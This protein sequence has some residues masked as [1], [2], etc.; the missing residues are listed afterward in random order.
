VSLPSFFGRKARNS[1]ARARGRRRGVQPGLEALG[2]RRLLSTITVNT[3]AD[4]T[5]PDAT[6]SLRQAIEVS[7]GTLA[8]SSLSTQEQAL[9]NGAVSGT[10]TIDFNI[11]TTDS[12][13]DAATGVWAIAVNSALPA[14]STNAAII[15]GYSQAGSSENTEAQADNA[16]L[17]IAL[18]GA[19][20]Q[21]NGLTIAQPGSHVSG[22]DI[23][24]FSSS[25]ILITAAGDVQV[26][27]CFIGTDPTGA[28]AAPNANGV[29][30]ENSSNLIGGPSAGDRNVIS[31]NNQ[32][33]EGDGILLPPQQQNP[34][35]ITPTEN[36]VENNFIG[37]DA[38]GT[39][40]LANGHAGVADFGTAN[41][42]GGTTAGL[43]NVISGNG[44]G[45]ITS[46]SSI[47][48]EG[49]FIG[50]DATGNVALGNGPA[51]SGISNGASPATQVTTVITN[52]VVSGN[53]QGGIGVSV[54]DQQTSVYT[55]SNNKIGTNAAGTMALGNVGG[56]LN[57]DSIE[58]AT[59]VGNL[60]SGNTGLGLS[61]SGFGTDVEHNVFQGNLIGTDITGLLDL[62]NTDA[63]VSF[64]NAIGNLFGGSSAGQGNVVAFNGGDGI[65][66]EETG[67][68][69]S[70]QNRITENSIFG[71]EGTGIYVF[72]AGANN[73]VVPPTLTFTPLSGGT[74]TLKATLVG[75]A[76]NASYVVE[77]FSNPTVP[78]AGHVAETTFIEAM[79]VVADGSGHGS[80]SVTVPTGVYTATS[81]DSSGNT[82][83]FSLPVG[84]P[85]LPATVTS[86]TS[87]LNSSTVGQQVTFTA[88]VTAGASPTAPTGSVVFT[89]DG[90][91]QPSVPLTVVGG[92]DEAQFSTST[93]IAG[94]HSISAA[95]SGDANFSSS[96]GT[97]PTQT[98]DAPNLTVTTTAVSSSSN[99]SMVGQQV[100]FTAVVAAEV[101]PTTPTGSVVFTID[102]HA[103]PPVPLTVVGGVDEAQFAT[104]TLAAR[105]HSVSATYDGE[106]E[107]ATSTGTLPTQTV[108]AALLVV[109]STV[110]STT[111][112]PSSLGHQVVLTAT[113][114]AADNSSVDG[115]VTFVVGKTPVGT[116]TIGP[117]GIATFDDPSLP[118]GSNVITANYSGDVMH[119]PSTSNS[120]AQVVERSSIV[121]PAVVAPAVVLLQRYGYHMQPTTLVLTFN[122]ALDAASAENVHAY[123]IV[124]GSGRGRAGTL[125][126]RKVGIRK[127][128]YNPS[129][130]TVTLV[131]AHRLDVHDTYRLMVDG[132]TQAGLRGPSGILLDAIAVGN[133]GTNYH[134]LITWRTLAG[135]APGFAARTTQ[136]NVDKVNLQGTNTLAGSS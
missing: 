50:T 81:T 126:G 114:T 5:T 1:Q 122:T 33:G 127:A 15:D 133:P 92:V 112:S 52:N 130:L 21:F 38:A 40:A 124:A 83:V 85:G 84:T 16:R 9:V 44:G 45:G 125:A 98:V 102:G 18:N 49:N 64:S 106:S 79:T 94:P 41:T 3:T 53:L 25:G 123:H 11:P 39:M 103:Q 14:I 66:I 51:S 71:N 56:G 23:E 13:Y 4:D 128:I 35:D 110:L 77:I 95:Y 72:P 104:S 121:A 12:G 47:T 48:I 119:A 70:G 30:I 26:A 117:N 57:L 89:I 88:V 6:L 58:N 115:T 93:L 27:G 28:M 54:G 78:A 19:G 61:L 91:A 87:S 120:V 42:Y 60:I 62:G 99:P 31:G 59:V 108:N 97:L 69:L 118:A 136:T 111:P 63:G 68:G 86:V 75:G 100:T 43:G 17:T 76:A 116:G 55:I 101:S 29:V 131:P 34:L 20:Q 129:A 7:N 82:S 134:A 96:T 24:N 37:I 22:L 132:T 80:F 105:Q 2:R 67:P 74:G 135:P 73:F 8:V 107:F 10:N 46:E 109:T 65:D 36:V 32:A 90:H 113:V